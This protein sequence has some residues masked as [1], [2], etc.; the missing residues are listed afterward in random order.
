MKFDFR[1]AVIGLLT[2]MVIV[3]IGS[4]VYLISR[5]ESLEERNNQLSQALIDAQANSNVLT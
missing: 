4:I 2:V 3:A 5:L 1:L